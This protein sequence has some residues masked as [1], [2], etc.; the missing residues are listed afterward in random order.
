MKEIISLLIDIITDLAPEGYSPSSAPAPTSPSLSSFPSPS[1]SSTS[2]SSSA[3]PSPSPTPSPSPHDCWSP[4]GQR[5]VVCCWRAMKEI[6]LLVQEI[7]DRVPLP[8]VPPPGD[9]RGGS[10]DVI[11]ENAAVEGRDTETGGESYCGG[12]LS[13][14]Q[15]CAFQISHVHTHTHTHTHSHTH[16][17]TQTIICQTHFSPSLVCLTSLNLPLSL[18]CRPW[19]GCAWRWC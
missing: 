2:P 10:E 13:V 17:H 6:G 15:V 14:E 8:H 12:V 9:G 18:R 11:H 1:H 7:V 16:S 19:G 4:V 3:S 5:I